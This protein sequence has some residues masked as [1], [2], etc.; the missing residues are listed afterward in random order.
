VLLRPFSRPGG[1]GARIVCRAVGR[2]QGAPRHKCQ[3]GDEAALL[4]AAA[5]ERRPSAV[6][7]ALTH[8]GRA[9]RHSLLGMRLLPTREGVSAAKA[10]TRQTAGRSALGQ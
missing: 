3:V 6:A 5:H 9:T 8:S 1:G 4:L 2:P 7:A 10:T